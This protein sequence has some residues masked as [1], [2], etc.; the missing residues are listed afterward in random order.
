MK[1]LAFIHSHLPMCE[2]YFHF[3]EHIS[4]AIELNCA[5]LAFLGVVT[6]FI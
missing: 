6:L 4:Y 3:L 5:I 1:P 2:N